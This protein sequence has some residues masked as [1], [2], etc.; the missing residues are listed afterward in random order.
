MTKPKINRLILLPLVLML[1]YAVVA[2][3]RNTGP[4]QQY[5]CG[6]HYDIAKTKAELQPLDR[7]DGSAYSQSIQSYFGYYE[8]DFKQKDLKHIFGTFESNNEVLAAHI[9]KP[10]EYKATVILLHGFFDHTG[11]LKH[12]IKN[13]LEQGYA[14]AAY[15]MPGHGLSTGRRLAINNFSQYTNTLQDFTTIV[16][17]QLNGPY[18]LIGHSTGGATALDYLL[19]NEN[20]CFDK[21]ILAAPLVRCSSWRL[22]KISYKLYSPLG[23]SIVRVFRNNSSDREFLDFV[24]NK[25][26]LQARSVPLEWARALYDWNDKISD[27]NSSD[28]SIMIIQ[29]NKDTTVAWKFNIDFIRRKFT[30]TQVSLIDKARHELFNESSDIRA[31]VFSQINSYLDDK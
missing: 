30:N 28:K 21:I 15:D 17:R 6:Y 31:E 26:P 11:L 1:S 23:R 10:E 19:T 18:Y 8:L 9:F 24:R 13:L 25:D 27:Y 7:F 29:G 14:V 5:N 3:T 20:T 2:L 4:G 16:T 22:S 12:L